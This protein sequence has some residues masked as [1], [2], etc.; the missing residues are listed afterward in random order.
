MRVGEFIHQTAR[1]ARAPG[2]EVKHRLLAVQEQLGIEYLDR[3]VLTERS[4]PSIIEDPTG[5]LG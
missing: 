4:G 2:H 3:Q 5:A 1:I